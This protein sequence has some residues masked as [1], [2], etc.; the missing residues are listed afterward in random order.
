MMGKGFDVFCPMGL[1]IVLC[2]EILD[3]LRLH[4][5]SYVNG[6]WQQFSAI[7]EILFG[8]DELIEFVSAHITLYLRD[9]PSMG[10]PAGVGYFRA[11]PLHLKEGDAAHIEVD[12][13][14]HLTNIVVAE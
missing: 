12:R 9:A 14:G 4:A 2:D 7:S 10:T 1:E 6:E 13:I 11:P 5:A 3:P 8:M